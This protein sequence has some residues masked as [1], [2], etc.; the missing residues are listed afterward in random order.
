MDSDNT[1]IDYP[2]SSNQ[3]GNYLF[4]V[5]AAATFIPGF[6]L[7]LVGPLFGVLTMGGGFAALPCLLPIY[8]V[9]K[10]MY[11]Q[12]INVVFIRLAMSALFFCSV[13]LA[14]F[15][16]ELLIGFPSVDLFGV[17][18][19]SPVLICGTIA[20]WNFKLPENI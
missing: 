3:I 4:G 10:Y 6:F 5:W 11:W 9:I 18:F 8:F 19:A 1:T 12:R 7:L 13:V 17:I 14:V 15:F 20:V 2:E 16:M